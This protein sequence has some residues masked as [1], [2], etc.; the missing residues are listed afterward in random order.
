MT[1]AAE[2]RLEYSLSRWERARGEGAG[3]PTLSS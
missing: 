2:R 3:K 1:A